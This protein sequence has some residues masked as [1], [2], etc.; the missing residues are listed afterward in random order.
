MKVDNTNPLRQA[1]SAKEVKRRS[2]TGDFAGML[3][4]LSSPAEDSASA[5]EA[6]AP[7][8]SLSAMLSVQ[9]V[10]EEPERKRRAVAYGNTA[11]DALEELR[12][13]L[14]TGT[15][16]VHILYNITSILERYEQVNDPGLAALINDIHLRASVE[17]AKLEMAAANKS[18]HIS[19][20]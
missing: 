5:P 17:L 14:L 9:E 10:G 13:G 18:G 7:A 16:P 11:L 8:S 20:T 12:H 1:S 19:G 3:D 4:A 6:P 15:L 2:A